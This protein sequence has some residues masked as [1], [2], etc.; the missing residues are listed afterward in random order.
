MSLLMIKN[1][2]YRMTDV[3]VDNM[4]KYCIQKAIN[5][6]EYTDKANMGL[7]EVPSSLSGILDE[8]VTGIFDSGA[9]KRASIDELKEIVMNGETE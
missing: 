1:D 2:D 7:L 3:S 8:L 9:A 6:Q 4:A 5:I